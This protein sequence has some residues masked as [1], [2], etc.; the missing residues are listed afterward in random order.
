MTPNF[1]LSLSAEGLRLLQRVPGGWHFAGEVDFDSDTLAKDIAAL[2]QTALR[3]EPGGIHCKV[4]IPNDQIRYMALDTTRASEADVRAALDGATPYGVDDLAYDYSRGGGRTYIAAVASETLKEAE[5]FC[6]E[7][8][9]NPVSFAAV[10]EPFTFVGEPFFGAAGDK[11]DVARDTAPVEVIGVAEVPEPETAEPA[12]TE[13]AVVE[14]AVAE[15]DMTDPAPEQ[16]AAEAQASKAATKDETATADAPE[17]PAKTDEPAAADPAPEP[18]E[19]TS[20]EDGDIDTDPVAPDAS[21][22]KDT[23]D[24]PAPD[25]TAE[26][27]HASTATPTSL[28]AAKPEPDADVADAAT[29][30][31][32]SPQTQET[33][34][35]PLPKPESDAK[36]GSDGDSG[37]DHA[38]VAK[39]LFSG[40]EAAKDDDPVDLP[41]L[42]FASRARPVGAAPDASSPPP[43]LPKVL[44]A[45]GDEPVF[46]SRSRSGA[47]LKLPPVL[48]AGAD[49]TPDTAK[50]V[51]N[52]LASLK[53]DATSP[54]PSVGGAERDTSKAVPA[55]LNAARQAALSA[56]TDDTPA[57]TSGEAPFI[58]ESTTEAEKLTLFGA[59]KKAKT[60]PVGGKPR[61]LGLILVLVLLAFLAAVALWATTLPATLSSLFGWGDDTVTAVGPDVGRPDLAVS[62]SGNVITSLPSEE[63]E[64][65]ADSGSG[66]DLDGVVATAAHPD[67]GLGLAEVQADAVAAISAVLQPV[68]TASA[69]GATPASDAEPA[70]PTDVAA[71]PADTAGAEAL[72]AEIIAALRAGA[73]ETSPL[74]GA[75]TDASDLGQILSPAEAQR[76]Y[77]ATGVWQRAPRMPFVPRIETGEEVYLAAIDPVTTGT[78]AVALPSLALSSPDLVLPAQ[79]LPPQPG[80]VFER[81]ERGFILASADGTVLPSGT[82]VYAGRPSVVPPARPGFVA[83]DTTDTT[84]GDATDP[85][86]DPAAA[87]TGSTTAAEQSFLA[88]GAEDQIAFRPRARPE[89][90]SEQ[91]ERDQ[92][93]GLTLAEVANVRPSAR[94]EGL[95][96]E[97]VSS[98]VV[99]AALAEA[100]GIADATPQAVAISVRPDRRP[101][102]FD[103]VVAAARARAAPAPAAASTVAPTAE[104]LADESDTTE[105][106]IAN[107]NPTPGGVAQAAT[108]ENV[109]TLRQINLIGVYGT[110]RSRSALVRLS[111]GRIVQV[112]VGD[113]LDGGQVSAIGDNALNYVKRGRTYALQMP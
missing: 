47:D 9:F 36:D 57:D 27:K 28:P 39:V 69:T 56:K 44:T 111:N 16:P 64:L 99:E 112:R 45:G 6:R 87:E 55:V 37:D 105:V 15:T 103:Q 54:A 3:L 106:P 32:A 80:T 86:A 43:P 83:P 23:K 41:P 49:A 11:T 1:A 97:G 104:E 68:A 71:A 46:A 67:T 34:L 88:P 72:T 22:A 42:T 18:V 95:V 98:T 19:S 25:Q 61:F 65:L 60:P 52:P 33:P 84:T 12:V 62:A 30:D 38:A 108:D 110:T 100:T 70:T 51:A 2:R 53:V 8:K 92:N 91:I 76:I 17:A 66:T 113:A 14:A 74:D 96:P 24:K 78:D 21:A 31:S 89:D 29:G 75:A 81:D 48:S 82:V 77:A 85:T 109:L 102:N 5:A 90:L 20:A 35:T 101:Q 4:L 50:P 7:H 63:E 93:G 26:T 59:R 79:I 13:P 107:A 94:P 10:P 40:A 73:V 58:D